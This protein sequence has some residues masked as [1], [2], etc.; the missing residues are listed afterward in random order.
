MASP[1]I[2]TSAS[3]LSEAGVRMRAPKGVLDWMSRSA[4]AFG[5]LTCSW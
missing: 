2:L 3:P 5:T 4:L 1:A